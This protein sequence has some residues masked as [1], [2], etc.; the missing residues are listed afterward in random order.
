M[1]KWVSK[2]IHI[3]IYLQR[4]KTI[5]M[6]SWVI[7]CNGIPIQEGQSTSVPCSLQF[8]QNNN[9][10]KEQITIPNNSTVFNCMKDYDIQYIDFY[11]KKQLTEENIHQVVNMM[12]VINTIFSDKYKTNNVSFNLFLIKVID[13]WA[14]LSNI[15]SNTLSNFHNNFTT[16]ISEFY[17]TMN[18]Q[19]M[20]TS[21]YKLIMNEIIQPSQ[22]QIDQLQSIISLFIDGYMKLPY[23][24]ISNSVY[25]AIKLSCRYMIKLH[26]QAMF[27]RCSTPPRDRVNNPIS[28]PDT[29]PQLKRIPRR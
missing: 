23:T 21:L 9:V 28:A 1:K 24:P 27:H 7:K 5:K 25:V 17:Q 12:K 4:Q 13:S 8:L 3:Y 18:K 14:Y 22:D 29:P 6:I 26:S 19:S 10:S 16:Y 15:G 11:Q 2:D 20:F